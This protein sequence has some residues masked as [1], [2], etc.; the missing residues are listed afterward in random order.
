MPF[1]N[2]LASNRYEKINHTLSSIS[3]PVHGNRK[4]AEKTALNY[5]E[6]NPDDWSI[7]IKPDCFCDLFADIIRRRYSEIRDEHSTKFFPF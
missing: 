7:N 4:N 1:E 3:C 2:Q 5:V 6:L